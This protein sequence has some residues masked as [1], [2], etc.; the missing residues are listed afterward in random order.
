MHEEGR[1]SDEDRASMT[2]QAEGRD[3][4]R[5]FAKEFSRRVGSTVKETAM[6]P[7]R[8]VQAAKELTERAMSGEDVSVDPQIGGKAMQAIGLGRLPALKVRPR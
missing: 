3:R 4:V 6:A 5:D 1:L 2:H 8:A 7:V